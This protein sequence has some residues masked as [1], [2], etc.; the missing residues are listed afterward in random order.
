MTVNKNNCWLI[1]LAVLLL[2][3]SIA[4]DSHAQLKRNVLHIHFQ[5]AV[6]KPTTTDTVLSAYYRIESYSPF[7]FT[8]FDYGFNYDNTKLAPVNAFFMGAIKDMVLST[9]RIT[10][11]MF[12]LIIRRTRSTR[13]HRFFFR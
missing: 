1:R 6:I 12:K 11:M 9:M 8:G 13:R 3:G 5:T 2:L 7:T 4:S 10:R